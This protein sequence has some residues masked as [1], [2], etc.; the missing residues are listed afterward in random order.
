MALFWSIEHKAQI[1]KFVK[2]GDAAFC[3]SEEFI[4]E[5]DSISM[6][7]SLCFML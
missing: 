6:L 1:I 4:G 3:V 2:S 7:Y 5:A